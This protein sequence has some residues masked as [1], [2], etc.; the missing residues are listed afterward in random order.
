VSL[1]VWV[2]PGAP[3]DEVV[4][5][6]DGRL[7]LRLA[8]RAHEGRANAAHSRF[9]ADLLGVARRDVRLVAGAGGRRKLLR[10]QGVTLDE[11]RRTLRL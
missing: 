5:M 4:G 8:A 9:V 2:T 3:R 10:I 11:A 7:R 1:A 6:A